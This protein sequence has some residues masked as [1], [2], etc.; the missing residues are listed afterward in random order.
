MRPTVIIS[1]ESIVGAFC[2]AG[3]QWLNA[4]DPYDHPDT[5]YTTYGWVQRSVR[6]QKDANEKA[7]L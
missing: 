4:A 5:Y 2:E 6:A 3:W 7:T 1:I